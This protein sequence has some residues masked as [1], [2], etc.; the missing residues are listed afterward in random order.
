[1]PSAPRPA[2][3]TR[4]S[5]LA[6]A[7]ARHL[8]AAVHPGANPLRRDIDRARGRGLLAAGFGLALSA[9]LATAAAFLTLHNDQAHALSESQRLHHVEATVLTPPQKAR[10]SITGVASTGFQAEVAWTYPAGHSVTRAA[11]VT[12]QAA[13]GSTASIWVNRSGDLSAPPRGEADIV[14]DS[15]LV[16][17]GTLGILSVA[18]A[19]LLGSQHRSLDRQADSLWQQGWARVEPLWSG[20]TRGA[21]AEPC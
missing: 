14:A 13:P 16:G 17:L 1:M 2:R 10:G 6:G 12:A 3:P 9:G 20:R 5:I 8:R 7:P 15:V 19:T 18:G 4:G 21:S 11:P